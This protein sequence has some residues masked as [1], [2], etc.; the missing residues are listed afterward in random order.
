MQ[1]ILPWD[2]KE[3]LKIVT[4]H[5]GANWNKGFDIY[6]KIDNL[7][8]KTE[9]KNKIDFTYI[10][11]LPNNFNFEI[12]ITYLHC[13]DKIWQMRSKKTTSMLPGLK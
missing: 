8:G 11:N 5:W 6:S 2:R 3:K 1:M 4:H 12:P 9:W 7:I 13:P 10:G